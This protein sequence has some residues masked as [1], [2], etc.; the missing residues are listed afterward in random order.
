MINSC[1]TQKAVIYRGRE[2]WVESVSEPI[3][4]YESELDNKFALG[5]AVLAPWVGDSIVADL[6]EIE[7]DT[8]YDQI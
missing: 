8:K 4:V 2:Y 3:E 6:R 7:I 5:H 1:D